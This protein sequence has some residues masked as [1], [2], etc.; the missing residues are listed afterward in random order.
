M[1]CISPQ[2]LIL[3]AVKAEAWKKD[4]STLMPPES[5]IRTLLGHSDM[6][7]LGHFGG[8]GVL[9]HSETLPVVHEQSRR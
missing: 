6:S 8:S 3:R 9:A 1:Q 4:E 7:N 2:M 5:I